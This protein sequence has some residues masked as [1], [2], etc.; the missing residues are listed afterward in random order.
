MKKISN[1]IALFSLP[2][3]GAILGSLGGADNSSKMY[4]RFF[5]PALLTSYA[6]SN[7]ESIFVLTI[8]SM[9]GALSLG[10]GIPSS[11]D[12]GSFIGRFF[13][14]LFN[15]NET[16]SNIFTRGFIRLL[17]SLSLI[18]ILIIKKNFLIYGLGS[19]GIILTNSFVS[20]RN[21]GSYKLFKKELSYVETINWGLIT[22]F[23]TLICYL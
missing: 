21:Y 2:L 17:I 14:N 10:Y 9:M 8:M 22:L 6:F 4:R 20:W 23:G 19:L 12:E 15:H 16:L 5:I 3:A 18:S 1:K 7:T 11:D 13:Y